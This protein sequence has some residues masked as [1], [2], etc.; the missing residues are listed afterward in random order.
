MISRREFPKSI[1]DGAAVARLPALVAALIVSLSVGRA[2]EKI[3]START[4]PNIVFI[5]ADDMGIGDISSYNAESLIETPNIDKLASE[6][7]RFTDTHTSGSRCVP[8]RYGI[9]IGQH[10][11]FR[12]AVHRPLERT[13]DG[14]KWESVPTLPRMLKH[15]GYDTVMYGKWHLDMRWNRTSGRPDYTKPCKG[16]PLAW[17]FDEYFGV[18]TSA[19]TAPL[20][21]FDGQRMVGEPSPTKLDPKALASPPA[22][23]CK[24]WKIEEIMPVLTKKTVSF[25]RSREGNHKPFFLYFAMTAPHTPLVPEKRFV[26][27]GEEHLQLAFVR[28]VDWSVGEVL[29]AIDEAG[30]RE[31]TLV[32]F[33]SDNGS[34]AIAFDG[35]RRKDLFALGKHTAHSANGSWRGF[36]LQNWEGGHRVPFVLRWPGVV[37]EGGQ[38]DVPFQLTD[39]FPTFAGIINVELPEG[40]AIDGQVVLA[41][42][43]GANRKA[44][45]ASRIFVHADHPTSGTAIRQG[46]WKLIL[47]RGGQTGLYDLEA[48]PR[49]LKNMAT[50]HPEVVERLKKALE[51]ETQR[52]TRV[53]GRQR[54]G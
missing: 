6:G 9:M 5:L 41:V 43:K 42:W 46:S 15:N 33:S 37:K 54:S 12:Q 17:G 49:E 29:K 3:S 10:L 39:L 7:V 20:A 13:G 1:V 34:P 47:H 18:P 51:V 4:F 44:D 2:G 31:N 23:A 30:L 40:V 14:K 52:L 19:N 21:F 22:F 27:K 50:S 24:G 53:T 16:G 32:I 36:K 26:K 45:H 35:T 38:S 28:Q 48:D 8:S 25:I 11:Y